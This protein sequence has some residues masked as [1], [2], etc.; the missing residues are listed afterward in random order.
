VPF[1]FH[2]FEVNFH[3]R[4]MAQG[5]RMDDGEGYQRHL[6]TGSRYVLARKAIGCYVLVFQAL[7]EGRVKI[8]LSFHDPVR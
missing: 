5:M 7:V 1:T 6:P 2:D 3:L 8:R 4:Y